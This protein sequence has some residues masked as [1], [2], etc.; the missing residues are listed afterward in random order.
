MSPFTTI[1]LRMKKTMTEKTKQLTWLTA[2]DNA[3]KQQSIELP[4]FT[5]HGMG[6]ARS[7]TLPNS[8]FV[9]LKRRLIPTNEATDDGMEWTL[10]R[11]QGEHAIPEITFRQ[12]LH[13]ER[14]SV[15]FVLGVLNAWLL[16]N[17][18]VDETKDA[19][20]GHAQTGRSGITA[21]PIGPQE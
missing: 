1:L 11:T 2:I 19:I 8:R 6:V 4:A 20:H 15:N 12:P 10:W 16:K 13:P 17:W 14:D 21:S 18:T 7:A 3:A 9:T 5:R